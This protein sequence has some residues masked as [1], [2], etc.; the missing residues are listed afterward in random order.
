MKAQFSIEYFTS[1]VL[2]VGFVAYIFLQVLKFAPAYIGELKN[3]ETRSE[4]YQ[5]SELLVNDA[6]Q[7]SNWDL[8][9]VQRI[10]F[11]DENYNK[12]NLLSRRKINLISG[13]GGCDAGYAN[14]QKNIGTTHQFSLFLKDITNNNILISCTPPTVVPKTINVTVRRVVALDTNSYGELVLQMW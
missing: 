11:S 4:A 2:F 9:T 1:L 7:P 13:T 12:T 14:V 3:E 8:S 6:G 10:G 5:V